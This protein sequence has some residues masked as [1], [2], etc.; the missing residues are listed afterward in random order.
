MNGSVGFISAHGLHEFAGKLNA[1]II[2]P[3]YIILLFV[4][5]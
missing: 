3:S 4:D 1:I 2:K 5:N